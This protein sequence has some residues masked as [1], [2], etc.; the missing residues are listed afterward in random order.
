MIRG[1]GPITNDYLRQTLE[2]C[3]EIII[4]A[5]GDRDYM[6]HSDLTVQQTTSM[7]AF[8]RLAAERIPI[9]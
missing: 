8:M 4:R 1:E 5:D 3:A 2:Q 7:A 9:R 6:N